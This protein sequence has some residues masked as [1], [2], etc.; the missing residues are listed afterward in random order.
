MAVSDPGYYALHNLVNIL[1][2]SSELV[3]KH[4]SVLLCTRYE[5]F[6]VVL[7]KMFFCRLMLYYNVVFYWIF[8]IT[9][10]H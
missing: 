4:L 7:M 5:K 6:I 1:K 9:I 2:N 3:W 8:V 10:T